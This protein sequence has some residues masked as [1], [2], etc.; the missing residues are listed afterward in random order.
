MIK[1]KE[2]IIVE[3]KYDKM[4]LKP[5]VDTT[6]IE[7]NGFRIFNDK[8]K[9][10]LIKRLAETNG[11]LVLTDSDSAGFLI[12]N[13]LRGI[14]ANKNIKHAYVPQILGKEKRKEKPSK[15]GTLGVEGIQEEILLNAIKA[16]VSCTDEEMPKITKQ[17]MY[18]LGLTGKQ[19]S[20]HLREQLLKKLNLPTY[21][22][23]NALI[24]VLSSLYCYDELSE[25]LQNISI[26]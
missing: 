3:G 6:I 1:I 22:S 4:R 2:T 24:D 13:C 19:N 12:R 17:Q 25:I 21:L 23:T 9:Q 20:K 10:N 8:Q 11:I 14:T 15:E 7:T 26:K 18:E 5:L 16:A